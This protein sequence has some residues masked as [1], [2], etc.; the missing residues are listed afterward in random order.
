MNSQSTL[1]KH[2]LFRIQVEKLATDERVALAYKRAKLML[3]TH[4]MPNL[5][6]LCTKVVDFLTSHV[7]L[8]RS[9]QQ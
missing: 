3:S 7:R 2:P 4:C 5:F 6:F 1:A 8:R 9:T